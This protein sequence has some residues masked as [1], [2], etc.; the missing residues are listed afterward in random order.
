MF[1]MS[2]FFKFV[3][4]FSGAFIALLYFKYKRMRETRMTSDLNGASPTF[5]AFA[6]VFY[7]LL[8]F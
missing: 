2:A 6:P 8:C 4:L 5:I 7:S 3:V 1:R